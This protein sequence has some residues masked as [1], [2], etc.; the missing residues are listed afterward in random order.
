MAEVK[1]QIDVQAIRRRWEHLPVR[2]ATDQWNPA[3]GCDA[4]D[5]IER[6]I[7]T[8][9]DII[10]VSALLDAY[11]AKVRENAELRE[12]RNAAREVIATCAVALLDG[13]VDPELGPAEYLVQAVREVAP[14]RAKVDAL[15]AALADRT[16]EGNVLVARLGE[17]EAALAEAHSK[18]ELRDRELDTMSRIATK[19]QKERDEARKAG[20]FAGRTFERIGGDV[21]YAVILRP[22]LERDFADYLASPPKEQP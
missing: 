22:H 5:G 8:R 13:P 4:Y 6:A 11:E 21:R 2:L 3:D 15:T 7:R 1:A 9:L 19:Y 12:E 17:T 18:T 14:L 16:A 20:F 10:A